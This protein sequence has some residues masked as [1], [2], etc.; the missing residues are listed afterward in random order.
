MKKKNEITILN[1]LQLSVVDD[2]KN[3]FKNTRDSNWRYAINLVKSI[4]TNLSD[5]KCNFVF[6]IP[7][8]IE[9]IGEL[10]RNN[11]DYIYIPYSIDVFGTRFNFDFDKMC[12]IIKKVKP[13]FIFNNI[14]S[15]S[16]NIKAVIHQSN[17]KSK[18]LTFMH[19]LDT[20]NDRKVPKNISY[21][22]RQIESAICSDLYI[23]NSNFAIKE[24]L[25]N[26]KKIVNE[27]I[28]DSFKNKLIK[29]PPIIDEGMFKKLYVDRHKVFTFFFNHR[30][31]RLKQYQESYTDFFDL[32]DNITKDPKYIINVIVTDKTRAHRIK[33]PNI[34]TVKGLDNYIEYS[35]ELLK[36]HCNTN[37][38]HYSAMWSMSFA[39]SLL[40]GISTF[41]PDH[42]GYQEL[43]PVGSNLLFSSR[44]ELEEKI[45]LLY[46]D[47]NSF[48]LSIIAAQEFGKKEF[49]IKNKYVKWLVEYLKNE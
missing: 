39:E 2:K 23:F 29:M 37:L 19:W 30:L 8:N 28:I 15:L 22:Y 1:L 10:A 49:G 3:I 32:I 40:A 9:N 47:R 33:S 5:I 44:K 42:S 26:S 46:N 12:D 43:V 16:R 38:F 7:E 4:R 11:I 41:I 25:D 34:G 45:K 20:V 14:P 31:S 27:K 21:M 6:L 35:R 17:S 48:D 18:L 36:C 24:F 13:D